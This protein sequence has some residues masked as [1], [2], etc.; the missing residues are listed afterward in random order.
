VGDLPAWN[1][2]PLSDEELEYLRKLVRLLV[3]EGK[4]NIAEIVSHAENEIVTLRSR[5]ASYRQDRSEAWAR[6]ARLVLASEITPPEEVS[7]PT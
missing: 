2:A 3:E 6:N 5:V 4:P 1:P 7:S